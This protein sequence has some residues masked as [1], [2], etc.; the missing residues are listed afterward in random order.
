M[1]TTNTSWYVTVG[2]RQS[3]TVAQQVRARV[4]AVASRAGRT[5]TLTGR[6]D[7]AQPGQSVLLLRRAGSVWSVV[8]RARLS[9]GTTFTL[10]H[11]FRSA[12]RASLR[13][14]LP[15]D[16]TNAQSLSPTLKVAIPH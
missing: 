8:D 13:V 3:G 4:T 16:G 5:V 15:A 7:P 14:E 10:I 6:L 11:R 1:V 2:T 12:G 9:A